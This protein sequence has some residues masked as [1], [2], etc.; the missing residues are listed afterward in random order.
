MSV[1]S[2]GWQ[3]VIGTADR[4]YDSSLDS[5]MAALLRDMVCDGQVVRT[6]STALSTKVV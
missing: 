4:H 1:L 5:G 2:E 3:L 6:G